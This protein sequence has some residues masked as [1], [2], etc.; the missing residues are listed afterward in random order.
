MKDCAMGSTGAVFGAIGL[1]TTEGINGV[2]I[3]E[4][5]VSATDFSAAATGLA[6]G[7]ATVGLVCG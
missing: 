7:T 3:A 2:A 6:V 5:F 1:G 4:G